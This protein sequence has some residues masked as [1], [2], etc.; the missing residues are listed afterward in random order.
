MSHHHGKYK[1]LCMYG[2]V[3]YPIPDTL[4]VPLSS[5]FS[6]M[7]RAWVSRPE[8]QTDRPLL[9]CSALPADQK[10]HSLFSS[11]LLL[12]TPTFT[13]L[14]KLSQ[15]IVVHTCTVQCCTVS[16]ACLLAC[17][18]DAFH[19]QICVRLGHKL[20]PP[21]PPLKIH[22]GQLFPVFGGVACK[23]CFWA[24]NFNF[25]FAFSSTVCVC[26]IAMQGQ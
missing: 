25:Y 7:R 20:P 3:R 6:R 2:M 23:M 11:F 22:D 10:P 14:K 24:A 26:V 18:C 13:N 21:P 17:Y 8:T 19:L 12:Q 16:T 5:C 15:I 4:C 9:L 1:I